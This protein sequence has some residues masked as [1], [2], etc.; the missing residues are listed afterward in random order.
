LVDGTAMTQ[1]SK[2]DLKAGTG[3]TLTPVDNSGAGSSEVTISCPGGAGYAI[4]VDGVAQPA[5]ATIDFEHGAGIA[6]TPTV[7]GGVLHLAVAASGSGSGDKPF[8]YP[9]SAAGGAGS[10]F[11]AAIDLLPTGAAT[12]ANHSGP[13]L[14]LYTLDFHSGLNETAQVSFQLP[15]DWKLSSTLSLQLNFLSDT[16]SG[17]TTWSAKTF[18][19]ASALTDLTGTITWNTPVS[20]TTTSNV[21]PK[22][23]NASILTGISATGCSTGFTVWVQIQR[24]DSN[25][26]ITWLK[27]GAV[28]GLRTY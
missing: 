28:S 21:T 20:V 5:E 27:D 1:R 12:P 8:F 10:N 4:Q 14:T 7:S 19:A 3:C 25:T 9:F 22:T 13:S 26:G 6:I 17:V 16:G 15:G 2:A 18:C 23:R 11:G 24:T